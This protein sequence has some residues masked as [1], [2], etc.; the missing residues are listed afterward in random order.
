MNDT[1]MVMPPPPETGGVSLLGILANWR[2]RIRFRWELEQ[3]WRSDPHLIDDV[4]LTTR[5]V[6]TELTK[7]FWQA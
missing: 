5:Q 3:K 7:H 4:G 1:D 6:K 2:W